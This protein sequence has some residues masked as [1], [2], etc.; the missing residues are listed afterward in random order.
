MLTPEGLFYTYVRLNFRV[1]SFAKRS[2]SD[3]G[4]NGLVA[5]QRESGSG[6]DEDLN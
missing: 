3:L 4:V 1:L 2:D 5:S 6:L